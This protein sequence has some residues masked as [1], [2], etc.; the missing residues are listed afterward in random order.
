MFSR[1]ESRAEIPASSGNNLYFVDSSLVQ[2]AQSFEPNR[3]AKAIVDSG[4]SENRSCRVNFINN[5][6][7]QN[8]K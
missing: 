7:H 1:N 4:E 3:H 5:T 8:E 2:F 6:S